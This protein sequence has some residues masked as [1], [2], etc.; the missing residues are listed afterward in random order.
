MALTVSLTLQGV[1]GAQRI[2]TG[3]ISF[4]SSYPTDGESFTLSQLGF[5]SQLYHLNVSPKS[6][7]VFEV[8][9]TNKKLKAYIVGSTSSVLSEVANTTDLS[10]LTGVRFF[11]V[12]V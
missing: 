11:A 12:G 1:H 2:A 6:G 9:Y 10:A 8:D 7:Y 5:G 3:T 4:D